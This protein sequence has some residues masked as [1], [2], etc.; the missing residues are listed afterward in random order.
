M[1]RKLLFGFPLLALMLNGESAIDMQD[2]AARRIQQG[3]EQ[4]IE[5]INRI[6]D[7][8]EQREIERE[9]RKNQPVL[10]ST[11]H[12]F[13]SSSMPIT[14]GQKSQEPP[15]EQEILLKKQAVR[16]QNLNAIQGQFFAKNYKGTENTITID[17]EDNNTYKI[18]TRIAMTS[19]MIFPQKIKNFILG[20]NVGFEVL[21]VPNSQNTLAIRPKLIGVDTSLAVFT[22]DGKLYSFYIFSTDFK[23]WKNP[24]LVVFVKDKRSIVEKSKDPF[25]DEYFYVEEG[26]NKL[27]VKKKE[28]YKRYKVKVKKENTW[29]VPE[30][31]FSDNNYT[32]FKYDKNRYPQIPS[33]YTVI[34]KQ[35]SPIETRVIG[36]FVIAETV[37]DRFTIRIGEAY[38]CVEREKVQKGKQ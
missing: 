30:E 28:V 18:R 10:D 19:T 17:Y 33:I 26:I 25:F 11:S 3:Q 15:T 36:D 21:E 4:M 22:D 23:S 7:I 8:Q 34:D 29:L 27:R 5:T 24:H 32:F 38:V 35:D 14:Q 31:I 6:Q 1:T 37:A 12:D 2:E 9:Q 20:D 13:S 16:S